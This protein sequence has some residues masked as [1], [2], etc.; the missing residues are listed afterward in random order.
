[1]VETQHMTIELFTGPDLKSELEQT[2]RAVL[3]HIA[4]IR[5]E[6]ILS[7][8]DSVIIGGLLHEAS[9]NCPRLVTENIEKLPMEEYTET[10]GAYGDDFSAIT[11]Q[12]PRWRFVILF[13]GD[14]RVFRSKSTQYSL[15]PPTVLDLRDTELELFVDGQLNASQIHNALQAQIDNIQQQLS[16]AG[17]DCEQ[18]NARLR[19]DVPAMLHQRREQVQA[20]RDTQAQIKFPIRHRSG[21]SGTPVPL[22]K[23]SMRLTPQEVRPGSGPAP[24]WVLDDADY[25]EAL[26]VLRYWRDSLERAPSIAEG[27]GEEE[28]RDLLVAGLN[29]VFEGAAASEVFNGEGKTDILIRQDGV[30]VFIGECKIWTG[31]SSMREALDQIFK[32][33]VWR[34]IRTAVLLFVRN[35]D[36]TAV[37]NKARGIIQGRDN[38]LS[39]LV[40]VPAHQFNFVMHA[41]GDPEQQI[42]LAFIPFPLRPKSLRPRRS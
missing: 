40:E 18:H 41:N 22:T 17:A 33:A 9:A 21:S 19:K 24:R 2:F 25:Q 27:R 36:V 6:D 13:V 15:N 34:D 35:A 38:F 20:L 31:D 30:N 14:F 3:R 7:T 29:S 12:V 28:I 5:P 1:M 4:R 39:E 32:Y 10:I 26:R 23:T 8:P 42:R 37:V 16:Y 11:R